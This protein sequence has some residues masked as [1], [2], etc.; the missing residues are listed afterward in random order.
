M[1]KMSY[2]LHIQKGS[3]DVPRNE[4]T[5]TRDELMEMTTFQLRNICYKEK[6]VGSVVNNLDREGL[7]NTILRFRS[8]EESLFIES[9]TTGGFERIEAALHA[10]LNTPLPGADSIKIPAKMSLYAGLA[11]DRL[12][13][14]RVESAQGLS[15]SNVL[16]VNDY[17]E[18]CGI[19]QLRKEA[20]KQGRYMLF[21]HKDV[22]W[23]KTVNQSYSLLF[24]R[25]QD[26]DYLYKAY[27]EDKPLPPVNLHYYKVPVT[28]LEIRELEETDAVLAI[29]FGTSSTT[30]GAFLDHQYVS[31]P[32]SNDLLN[33]R[34]KL[35]AINYV[36]FPD[37]TQKTEEWI[38]VLPTVVQ[39]ADC[40]VAQD[41]RY[42]IGYEALRQMKKNG[43]SSHATVFF[44]L[45]RWVNSYHKLEEVMDSQGNTAMVKR[46]DILRQYLLHVIQTAEHQF[47]CRF[48]H[49]HIT[50][51]V[52][53]KTQF[54]EM[55]TDI[56][57]EYRIE[58]QDALDE[59][60]AVLFNT[61]ADQID[62]DSFLDGETY[63][64]LVIDCGGGTT[65]LSSCRF[66]IEDGHISYRIDIST[67][68]EN[69]DTNFGGNNITYRIMQFMKIVFADYYSK[70][71][72]VTDIDQLIDIPGSEI[73]RHVDEFGVNAVYEQFERRYR[74]AEA[75]LP[76]C[77]KAYENKSRDDYQRVRN[78]FHFLWD[79]ADHM[80]KEF[81]RQTGILR[82]RF[83][84]EG[85]QRQE[86]D[87]KLTT[88]ER[89]VLSIRE[90]GRFRDVYDLPDV[91]FN[92]KEINHLIKADI[93][94]ILRVFLDDFYQEGKL[95]DFSIIKLTGQSCRIDVFREALK[96][97][98][99]GRSIEFRQRSEDAGKVPDLKLSCLRGALRYQSAKK[100]GFIEAQITNH[101][102]VVPYSVTAFTHNR[103]ER[104]LIRSQ[105]KLSQVHG[106]ISRPYGVS[107]VEFFLKES[108]GLLRKRYLYTDD[109]SAYK[110]VLYEEIQAKYASHI[111]QEETDSI[112]NG[113]VKFFVFSG[114][115]E[116]GFHVV[117]VARQNEQL[118][119]GKKVFFAF[120]S[121]LSELDFFDGMK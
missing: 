97:F 114:G 27:T 6:L 99:P 68:Y 14:Y 47:K 75:L 109:R 8:A 16:L 86:Q 117:P 105:E 43:Y 45:K 44:G 65:D 39:V 69:G 120:E 48:R 22:P 79:L 55:F 52:K 77:Y 63:Q 19:F 59:G 121:D 57:P 10:Y 102:P 74:E 23:R 18:L 103:Q 7:L 104:I 70:G 119:L 60:M 50:S 115:S 53:L 42:H 85:E 82:N 13:G 54:I 61:I 9:D 80:K 46:S 36:A 17:M 40:S 37:T 91:V 11:V 26:S 25:K 49:L 58:S 5:Y 93:Y 112:Q 100:A 33:G 87:L 71:R 107:E 96:E 66:R 64:A 81:F 78:N 38:E 30:A 73:F 106:A 72:H 89:W 31:A 88:V 3:M 24:F 41:V 101:A 56:L 84:A 95:A 92:S 116:W 90:D 51:P 118:L 67:T 111:P 28:D 113:E 35:N 20:D 21:S 34:I 4:T 15:E 32:S 12:D 83:T 1:S 62:K 76:T 110:P 2:K 108:D 98:V 29:D 94:E